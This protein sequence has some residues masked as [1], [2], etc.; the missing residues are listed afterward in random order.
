MTDLRKIKLPLKIV[1]LDRDWPACLPACLCEPE[2][3]DLNYNHLENHSM[4]LLSSYWNSY[5]VMPASTSLNPHNGCPYSPSSLVPNYE[6][7]MI[8]VCGDLPGPG[9]DQWSSKLCKLVADYCRDKKWT[10]YSNNFS[11]ITELPS[12]YDRINL[13]CWHFQFYFW[14]V[15]PTCHDPARCSLLSGLWRHSSSVW[16]GGVWTQHK[17]AVFFLIISSFYQLKENEGTWKSNCLS[18]NVIWIAK[19]K[20]WHLY[21][22]AEVL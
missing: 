20:L 15:A 9:N 4:L 10:S 2:I 12:F 21:F 8:I 13:A 11:L 19:T 7:E 18:C 1:P 16:L 17:R 6:G 3:V 5:H 22:I 14:F